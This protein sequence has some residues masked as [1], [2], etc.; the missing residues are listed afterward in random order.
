MSSKFLLITFSSLTFVANVSNCEL[1]IAQTK[2]PETPTVT[3]PRAT[4]FEQEQKVGK[5][6]SLTFVGKDDSLTFGNENF[7]QSAL[8]GT[9]QAIEDPAKFRPN[10]VSSFSANLIISPTVSGALITGPLTSVESALTNAQFSSSVGNIQFN[11]LTPSSNRQTGTASITGTLNGQNVTGNYNYN[12]GYSRSDSNSPSS[13]TILLVNPNN[14]SQSLLI[15]VPPQSFS[16][17]RNPINGP[18]SISI[19]LPKD[20]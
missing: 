1:A 5:D 16:G 8:S 19:G 14:P 9:T 3:R 10:G 11:S 12:A 2:S 7:L 17:G 13:A 18:A 6:D 20:R 4:F 15:Q